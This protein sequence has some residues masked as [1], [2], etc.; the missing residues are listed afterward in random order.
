MSGLNSLKLVSASQNKTANPME[1]KRKKLSAKLNEQ[2]QLAKA[3]QS[4]SSYAPT[5][6]KTV[7]DLLTGESKRVERPKKIKPWWW[8]NEN[9]KTCITV[10]Y[11]AKPLELAKGQ[12][13]AETSG[14][15]EVITTLQVIKT[16]VE[17]GDLDLQIQALTDKTPVIA[18][19]PAPVKRPIL[20]LRK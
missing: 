3:E 7:K 1:L 14:I 12:N 16:A 11:G 13:A 15:A 2:I 20:G 4:G 10:R 19:E 18:D 8:Q 9:G 17:A 6:V 5:V